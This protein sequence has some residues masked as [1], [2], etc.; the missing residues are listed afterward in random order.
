MSG[1]VLFCF[2]CHVNLP[3]YVAGTGLI[4]DF[5]NFLEIHPFCQL[6]AL[7]DISKAFF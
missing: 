5:P 4:G 1:N 7:P 6:T 3:H 2:G